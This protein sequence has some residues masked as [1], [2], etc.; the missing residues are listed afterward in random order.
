AWQA[1][2]P[3]GELVDDQRFALS[4]HAIADAAARDGV[5]IIAGPRR[6]TLARQDAQLTAGWI[7]PGEC[8][9]LR[10]GEA[11]RAIDDE[12]RQLDGV[13]HAGAGDRDLIE[14]LQLGFSGGKPPVRHP[15]AAELSGEGCG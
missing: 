7:V 13:E 9:G 2:F 11:T 12:H 8:R 6:A 15:L 14:R 3:C 5:R 10:T 1:P 4:K